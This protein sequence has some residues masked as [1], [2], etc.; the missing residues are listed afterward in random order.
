MSGPECAIGPCCANGRLSKSLSPPMAEGSHIGS[1]IRKDKIVSCA[2]CRRCVYRLVGF[3]QLTTS[4]RLKLRV[5]EF[6]LVSASYLIVA[7]I[8]VGNVTEFSPVLRGWWCHHQHRTGSLGRVFSRKRDLSHLCPNGVFS[9]LNHD[10]CRTDGLHVASAYLQTR[11][12]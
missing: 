6:T 9:L 10:E 4:C 3:L 1:R 5:H 11:P 8:C 2:E 12:R 7:P